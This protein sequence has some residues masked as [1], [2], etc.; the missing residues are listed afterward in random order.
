MSTNRKIILVIVAVLAF[1]LVVGGMWWLTRTPAAPQVPEGETPAQPVSTLPAQT[2]PTNVP[3]TP[4][5]PP[6]TASAE[7]IARAQVKATA[8]QFAERYGSY[9]TEGH[10]QNLRD[11]F[12]LMTA[13]L[14]QS[15]QAM[16]TTGENG[17]PT[18]TFVGVMT[19]AVSSKITA[20]TMTAATV[21]VACQR[22]TTTGSDSRTSYETLILEFRKE[23]SVWKADS[24]RWPAP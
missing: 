17:A 24:A 9:S 19:K 10:Y 7:D 20:F 2:A 3:V 11:L 21:E 12:P 6:A 8:M 15:T 16:I 13:A 18:T 4:P 23:G 1:V 22:V 14:K 5:P